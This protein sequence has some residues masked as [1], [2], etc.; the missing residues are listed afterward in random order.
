MKYPISKIQYPISFA[1][2]LLL[3]LALSYGVNNQLKAQQNA[4]YSQYMFNPFSMNPAYAGSRQSVSAVLLYRNHWVGIDGAPVSETFSIHS[5][6][7][8]KRVALGFNVIN[9]KIGP[10][11]NIG[12]FG[13]YAYH[14]HLNSGKLSMALRGGIYRIQVN[15]D[16]L[17]FKDKNDIYNNTS[18]TGKFIPSFDFGLYY[19]TKTFY[20]GAAVTHLSQKKIGSYDI[21]YLETQLYRHFIATVGKAFVINDNIV[22]KPSTMIRYLEGIPINMDINMSCLFKK[23]FWIGASYRTSK[24]LVLITEFNIT[25]YFRAGYS[26]DISLNEMRKYNS[27]SHEIFIGIDFEISKKKE[28]LCPKFL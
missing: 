14:L 27:G 18:I 7:K 12:A 6:F 1:F 16:I 23:V 2:K 8:G 5:P 26:Y 9:E 15:E 11:S 13:T 25:D 4:L 28:L 10:R 17:D 3:I 20:A 22:L 19:Y 24:D 21:E